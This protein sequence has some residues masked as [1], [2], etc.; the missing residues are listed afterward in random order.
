[1]LLYVLIGPDGTATAIVAEQPPAE[2]PKA[3]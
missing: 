2:L 3:A 1:M